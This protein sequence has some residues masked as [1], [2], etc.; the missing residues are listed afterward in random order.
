MTGVSSKGCHLLLLIAVVSGCGEETRFSGDRGARG[1][2]V[3]IDGRLAGDLTR[4]F[5]P[6]SDSMEFGAGF[7][8]TLS[9]VEHRIL[10]ILPSGDSLTTTYRPGDSG[11]VIVITDSTGPRI[12][13]H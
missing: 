12:L 11:G 5:F 2:K 6:G 10:V 4:E 9:G 1:S 13:T 7:G 3:Y 8:A